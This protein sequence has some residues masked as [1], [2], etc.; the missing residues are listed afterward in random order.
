MSLNQAFSY[1]NL[2]MLKCFGLGF[3]HLVIFRVHDFL[4]LGPFEYDFFGLEFF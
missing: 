2:F 4:D 1:L 3:S